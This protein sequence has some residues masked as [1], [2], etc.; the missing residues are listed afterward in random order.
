MENN[1]QKNFKNSLGF[2]ISPRQIRCGICNG[3]T[4]TFATNEDDKIYTYTVK[5]NKEKLSLEITKD[6]VT[7]EDDGKLVIRESFSYSERIAYKK[8]WELL[9]KAIK[10]KISDCFSN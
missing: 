10:W 7:Y 2:S 3:E 1:G 5:K 9:D 8:L 6:L 4:L